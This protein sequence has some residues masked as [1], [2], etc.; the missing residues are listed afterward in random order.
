LRGFSISVGIGVLSAILLSMRADL[1]TGTVTFLFTDVEGSTRRLDQLG[2]AAYAD[3]LAE[4]GRL[5]TSVCA[6]HGGVV[7]DTE[8]DAFFLAFPTASDALLAARTIQEGL[9]AGPLPVRIG[10]HTGAPLVTGAGYVGLDVHRAARIAGAAHGGQIVFSA[11]TRSLLSSS[12]DQLNGLV[13]RDLGEHRLKDLSAA[14]RLFQLGDGEFPPLRSLSRTNLPVASTPFMGR[15]GEL[16]EVVRLL[17][18]SDLRLLT[19]TGPGGTGKTRLALQAA[20]EIS[21][22]LPEGIWWVPLAPLR[23]PALVLP[24]VAQTLG[25]MEEQGRSL[26]D[27]LAARLESKQMLVVLDNAEHLLPEVATELASLAAACPALKLLATS[28]ERIQVAVETVWPVPPL[29]ARDAEQLFVERAR[30]VGVGL[31]AD[32]TVS[33]LCRRLD[34]L[35]LALELAAAR[36]VVFSPDQLLERLAQRLDLLKG[37]RDAD[38]RQQTMR[39]AIDWSYELLTPEEQRLFCTLS[40]FA[41]GCTFEAAEEVAQAEPDTLQSL[42]DK[43][44]LRRRET[45]LGPRYWMLGTIRDYAAEK[46]ELRGNAAESRRRQAEWSR[47]LAVR[48][49]GAPSLSVSRMASPGEVAR[50]R[51]DYDNARIALAWAWDAGLDDLGIDLGSACSRYWFGAGL[52]RDA[53]S[54]LDRAMPRIPSAPAESQLRGLMVGGLVAFFVLAD[55]DQADALWAEARVVADRLHLDDECAWIDQRRAGV[56]WERGDNE[57]AIAQ[58]ERLVAYHRAKGNGLALGESLHNLGESLRDVGEF[59]AAEGYLLEAAT[60]FRE[61]GATRELSQNTHSLGDLALDRGDYGA[62]L[63]LY[64]QGMDDGMASDDQRFLAYCL[65]GIASA[66]AESQRGE[67]AALIWGAVCSAEE[68]RGFR[69][70]IPERRRYEMHLTRLEESDAWSRGRSLTLADAFASLGDGALEPDSL[71]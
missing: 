53:S 49:L 37:G 44:L 8:G 30:S 55:S 1:P 68:S 67:E 51:D 12:D 61:I 34:D 13:V 29:E 26:T 24:S 31:D 16:A 43:S 59:E 19:L 32:E 70:L 27:T 41:S 2:D 42:L 40:V 71:D 25:V 5:I 18:R 57:E 20:A 9:A 56:A 50:F 11:S 33:E 62:A 7:V 3:E 52:F 36:T 60:V 28:R 17:R 64:R 4:H 48:M 22:E 66:L 45:Q 39:T 23:E 69:M 63:A 54:W 21:D 15:T 14:E 6:D 10:L 35:P 47:D 65:A 46:L 38:P 58:Y